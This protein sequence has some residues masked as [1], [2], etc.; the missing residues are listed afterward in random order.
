MIFNICSQT[1]IYLSSGKWLVA[2]AHTFDAAMIVE[3]PAKK[4]IPITAF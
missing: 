1:E 3:K 2:Q 4:D